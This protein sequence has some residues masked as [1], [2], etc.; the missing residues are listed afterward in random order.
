MILHGDLIGVACDLVLARESPLAEG[1]DN[2]FS[3]DETL[4]TTRE[5]AG[6]FLVKAFEHAGAAED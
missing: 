4:Q 3:V 6:E 5:A 1:A 2:G